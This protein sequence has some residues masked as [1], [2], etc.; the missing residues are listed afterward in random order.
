MMDEARSAFRPHT[1][2]NYQR[3]AE[4]KQRYD[5]SN[6]FRVN[7]NIRPSVIVEGRVR[8]SAWERRL[9]RSQVDGSLRFSGIGQGAGLRAA[10][11]L[12][13]FGS[14]LVVAK[15]HCGSRL[16]VW[17]PGGIAAVK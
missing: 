12:A 1:A 17:R 4:I 9:I 7:Q 14:V 5:P 6:F 15:T 3:L 13:P 2:T 8:S 10:I 16:G 11:E